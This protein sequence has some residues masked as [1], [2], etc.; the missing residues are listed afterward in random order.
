MAKRTKLTPEQKAAKEADKAAAHRRR[1]A[2]E[3]VKIAIEKYAA[4]HNISISTAKIH[5]RVAK[6]ANQH[7]ITH[8]EAKALLYAKTDAQKARARH[9]AKLRRQR[10][11]T[12]TKVEW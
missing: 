12:N 1:L 2:R 3:K 9:S 5:F 8:A 10:K 4:E 11:K 7:G 6:Y